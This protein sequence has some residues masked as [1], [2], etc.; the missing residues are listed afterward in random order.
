MQHIL[1]ICH[2]I[3][4]FLHHTFRHIQFTHTHTHLGTNK[5]DTKYYTQTI[6]K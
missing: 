5:F 1:C 2:L 4:E 3:V 6:D